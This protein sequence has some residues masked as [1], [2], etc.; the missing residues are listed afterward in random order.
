M[1]R[2]ALAIGLVVALLSLLPIYVFAGSSGDVNSVPPPPRAMG[3]GGFNAS[4]RTGGGGFDD[5]PLAVVGRA[6]AAK[7]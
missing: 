2:S 6:P 4:A 3:G 5:R 7:R 1:S